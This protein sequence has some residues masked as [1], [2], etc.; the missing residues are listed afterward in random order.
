MTLKDHW[1]VLRSG[2]GLI[3]PSVVIGILLAVAVSGIIPR[4]YEASTTVYVGQSLTEPSFDYGGLLASQLLTPTYARLVTT[5]ELLTAVADE[6]SLDTTPTE[7]AQR[8]S[9]DVP[10]GGT[11]I[12]ITATSD[13]PEGAADLSNAVAEEL[14]LRAP[15]QQIDQA[16]LERALAN[17]DQEIEATRQELLDLLSQ[18]SLTEAEQATVDQLQ[19]S[20]SIYESS[21]DSL[22]G[23]LVSRSP[24][25]VTIV[26][27]AA[28]PENPSGPS[29]TLIVLTAAASA[30]VLSVA[31]AYALAGLWAFRSTRAEA[32]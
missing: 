26:D 17:L 9:T 5:T 32:T 10:P 2:A 20:L 24:N 4:R 23:D 15:A 21:R 30:L 16:E 7:L 6:L 25:S 18:P 1:S 3:L 27:P 29:R 11:L 28:T 12:I 13:S 31:L 14:V 8:I 22:S 19:R